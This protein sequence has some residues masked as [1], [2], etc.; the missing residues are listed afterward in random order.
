MN[1]FI[2][3]SWFHLINAS[4]PVAAVL[5]RLALIGMQTTCTGKRQ[6][7]NEA[8]MNSSK[9]NVCLHRYADT[10]VEVYT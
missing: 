9:R 2:E 6:T 3:V 5:S 7:G 10:A 4:I 8:V 1:I